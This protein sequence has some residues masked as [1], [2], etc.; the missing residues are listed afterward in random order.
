M[1]FITSIGA[2]SLAS[3]SA[4]E[5]Q[6][7]STHALCGGRFSRIL[8]AIRFFDPKYPKGVLGFIVNL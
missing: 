1:S 8:N 3:V 6:K 2:G 5:P 4:A 7:A